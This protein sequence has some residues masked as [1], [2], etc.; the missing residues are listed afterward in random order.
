VTDY[1]ALPERYRVIRKLGSGGMG[2][3]WLAEDTWLN[4]KVALKQL[5]PAGGDT[6]D[7]ARRR[8]RVLQEARAL[9]K[10]KHPAIVPIH[11]LFDV[12]RDPWI[13]MEYIKG[14]SLDKLISAG[15]LNER[16]I[17]QIGLRVLGGL[18]AA[19]Q[20]GIVHRDVKP[21]NVIV[22]TS[23]AV[24]L[25]DFG[26]ARSASDPALTGM[27]IVGTMAYL[28]PELLNG[29]KADPA[30]DIWSLGVTLF[31]AL[32]GYSPFQQNKPNTQAI[33]TAILMETP[34]LTRRGPLAD[35]TLRMLA[36]D[37]GQRAVAED[38]RLALDRVARGEPKPPP[39]PAPRREPPVRPIPARPVT[40]ATAGRTA[41]AVPGGLRDEVLQAGPDEGAAMLASLDAAAAARILA[42]C[43]GRRRGQLLQ[44]VADIDPGAAATILPMLLA[45]AA[46]RAL[47]GLRPTSAASLLAA[48]PVP[49]AARILSSTDTRAAASAVME[50]LP[51][52]AAAQ[53]AFMPDRKRAA[54]VLSRTP[55]ES[56]VAI[57][58]ADRGF[59]RRVLPYLTGPL[60]PQVRQAAGGS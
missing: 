5:I 27:A 20:E 40:A 6:T 17:A 9:A 46:G 57:A 44:E 23:G 16:S 18:V 33:M 42:D 38:V 24:F 51:S 34:T 56:A 11:D 47:G 3:V 32:E 59:A 43:P 7:L 31:Y 50:L 15:R 49:E 35:I 48:M 29:A 19:H 26:I 10:I 25:I 28:A 39:E 12:K 30:A 4:R 58:R 8:R 13:V 1:P 45:D 60:Q 21:A 53:L 22:A 52:Q 2:H 41:T 55:S 14:H 54:E 37:P 36:K